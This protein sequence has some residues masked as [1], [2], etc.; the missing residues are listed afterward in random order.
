[1]LSI[2]NIPKH[3]TVYQ[4]MQSFTINKILALKT[5]SVTWTVSLENHAVM[6]Q[7]SFLQTIPCPQILLPLTTTSKLSH[8]PSH[9]QILANQQKLKVDNL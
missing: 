3:L 4:Y 6:I 8:I 1:M 9:G 7:C 2:L 5:W